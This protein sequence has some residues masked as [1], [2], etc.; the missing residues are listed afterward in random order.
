[1]YAIKENRFLYDEKN[2]III[3]GEKA[4]RQ[5]IKSITISEFS[6][7]TVLSIGDIEIMSFDFLFN[8]Q[9]RCMSQAI[10]WNW[11]GRDNTQTKQ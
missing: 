8:N 6:L 11:K 9:G 10:C 3:H 7:H 1:M 2:R 5:E 4:V